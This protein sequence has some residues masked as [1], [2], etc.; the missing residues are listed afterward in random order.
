MTYLNKIK[1]KYPIRNIEINPEYYLGNNI[2]VRENN[3][4]KISSKKY[5]AEV[6]RKYEEK[7]GSL[8]REMA[9]PNLTI[10]RKVMTHHS[11]ITRELHVSNL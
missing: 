2:E 9:Q 5:I 6:L 11:W 7:Y 8:K 1:A 10:I 4:I 3:T